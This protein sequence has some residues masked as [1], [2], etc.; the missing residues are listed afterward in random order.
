MLAWQFFYFKQ[1]MLLIQ[2]QRCLIPYNVE[3]FI[4]ILS[5]IMKSGIEKYKYYER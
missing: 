5:L 3:L 4:V 1:V 2:C